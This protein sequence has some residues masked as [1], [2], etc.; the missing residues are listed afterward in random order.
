MKEEASGPSTETGTRFPEDDAATPL[1]AVSRSAASAFDFG[2]EDIVC[3]CVCVCVAMCV[4]KRK[5]KRERRR[6]QRIAQ[7]NKGK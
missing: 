1:V 7:E 6:L 2:A 4:K 5:R 3:V